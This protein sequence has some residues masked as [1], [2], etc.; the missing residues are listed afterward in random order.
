MAGGYQNVTSE[1]LSPDV[2]GTLSGYIVI[3]RDS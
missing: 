1:I 2:R 3:S